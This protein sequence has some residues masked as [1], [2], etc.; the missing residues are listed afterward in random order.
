VDVLSTS[1][2][3][4]LSC[5]LLSC[6]LVVLRDHVRLR[7]NFRCYPDV[8]ISNVGLAYLG[9]SVMLLVLVQGCMCCSILVFMLF[10]KELPIYLGHYSVRLLC[11]H[12]NYAV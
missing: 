7:T 1:D 6:F 8:V 3:V 12:F 5:V 9:G 4:A 2:F 10:Y 11:V